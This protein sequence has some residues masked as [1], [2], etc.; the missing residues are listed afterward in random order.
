[1]VSSHWFVVA[2]G[3]LFQIVFVGDQ[4]FQNNDHDLIKVKVSYTF[5]FTPDH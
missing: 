3:S 4:H 5:L 1:M 2:N